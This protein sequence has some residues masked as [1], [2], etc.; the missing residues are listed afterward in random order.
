MDFLGEVPLDIAIRE[1]SDEGEPIVAAEP[2]GPHA[3]TF[4]DIAERVWAKVEAS[5]VQRTAKAPR[6]VVQ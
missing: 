2:D 4:L 1:R 3:R 6:I 5:L